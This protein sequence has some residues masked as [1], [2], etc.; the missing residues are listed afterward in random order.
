[1]AE[2]AEIS[3]NTV[4]MVGSAT[5]ND[6]EITEATELTKSATNPFEFSYSGPMKAG[7]LKFP[8]NRKSG[9]GQDS[10]TKASDTQM[11]LQDP[12]DVKWTITEAGNYDIVINLQTLAISIQKQTT[13]LSPNHSTSKIALKTN[14]VSDML[15]FTSKGDFNY[16]IFTASGLTVQ[17]GDSKNGQIDV[18]RLNSGVFFIEAEKNI[19]KFIKK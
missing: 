8:V 4:F 7:E 19:F 14:M 16:R 15:R 9:F 3:F 5:P 6:W 12:A 11:F 17:F 1:M 13:T 10:F 18:S 2:I